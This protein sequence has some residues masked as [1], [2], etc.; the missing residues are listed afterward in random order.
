MTSPAVVFPDG[1]RRVAAELLGGVAIVIALLARL[2]GLKGLEYIGVG[3]LVGAAL[4]IVIQAPIG[5]VPMGFALVIG[6]SELARVDLFFFIVGVGLLATVAPLLV[7]YNESDVVRRILR[8]GVAS[9]ACGGAAAGMKAL[10]GG[11]SGA[12]A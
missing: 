1:Q 8:W 5:S 11:T 7:G 4:L 3:L 6:L 12:V 2:D 9:A 10:V